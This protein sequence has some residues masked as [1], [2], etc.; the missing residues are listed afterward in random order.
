[1]RS[2]GE[3]WA[4]AERTD[5]SCVEFAQSGHSAASARRGKGGAFGFF[6]Y[7]VGYSF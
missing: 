3:G 1:M 7:E 2:R 4:R 5:V 6:P